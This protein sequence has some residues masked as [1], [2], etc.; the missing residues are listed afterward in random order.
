MRVSSKSDLSGLDRLIDKVRTLGD[1]SED[2]VEPLMLSWRLIIEEDNRKGVLA[3]LDKDGAPMA[4]V[5]YRPVASEGKKPAKLTPA[6]RN[7]VAPR[8]KRGVFAG[9]GPYASGLHNNLTTAEYRKLSGPPLAPRGA[10]SR[11]ITNLVTGY[12]QLSGGM[13]SAYGMWNEVV[14]VRGIAFL[15]YHFDGVGQKVRD[16][17]GVRPEGREKAR[18]SAVAWMLDQIKSRRRAG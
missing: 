9:H 16:L 12:E 5:T 11:V 2:K 14:S 13:W 7:G 1:L 10:F 4:P 3:G 6:Q 18:K 15:K 17:R 8:R